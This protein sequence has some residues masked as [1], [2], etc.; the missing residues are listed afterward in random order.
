MLEPFLPLARSI[1]DKLIARGDTIAVAD[2]ATGGLISAALLAIPG[3][4]KYY[5]GGGV[6]YTFR[7][8]NVLFALDRSAYEGMVSATESYALLQARAIR[9]NFRA[10]WGIAETGSAGGSPHPLGIDSGRSCAAVVGPEVERAR[11]TATE[12]DDRV[13]NMAAFTRAALELL[14]GVLVD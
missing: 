6:V 11:L 9:D 14:D 5:R 4:S 12:S 1:A 10:D 7:A 3:A 8:R 2:G 13:A